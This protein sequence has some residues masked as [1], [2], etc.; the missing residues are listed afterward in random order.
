MDKF[1]RRWI[2]FTFVIWSVSFV[3]AVTFGS[4]DGILMVFLFT[5]LFFGI[6]LSLV[7]MGL[8]VLVRVVSKTGF[9]SDAEPDYDEK[10]AHEHNM[11]YGDALVP[12]AYTKV[13]PPERQPP[14]PKAAPRILLDIYSGC[15]DCIFRCSAATRDQGFNA[16]AHKRDS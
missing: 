7:I 10:S 14:P 13:K 2:G 11:T 4:G 15:K 3:I 9:E 16:D 6:P 1:V 5:I 12:L 8:V